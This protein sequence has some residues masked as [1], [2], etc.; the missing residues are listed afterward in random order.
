MAWCLFV[1]QNIAQS[2]TDARAAQPEALHVPM[3][4]RPDHGADRHEHRQQKRLHRP[5]LRLENKQAHYDW[6]FNSN[7]PC[8]AM[9]NEIDIRKKM[10]KGC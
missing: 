4:C 2:E 6:C 7:P 10:L 5:A 9:T 1:P 8:S 3:V